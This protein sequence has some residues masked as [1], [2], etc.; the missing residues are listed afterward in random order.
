MSPLNLILAVRERDVR[1]INHKCDLSH[2]KF[3]IAGFEDGVGHMV[4]G[5]VTSRS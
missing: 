2:E 3:S 1:Y 5:Q 4:K